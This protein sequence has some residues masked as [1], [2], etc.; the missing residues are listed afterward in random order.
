MIERAV[1]FTP[2]L[3]V[4]VGT[5]CEFSTPSLPPLPF[6]LTPQHETLPSFSTAQVCLCFAEIATAVRP[7]PK[8]STASGVS[9]FEVEPLPKNPSRPLPQ[10]TTEPLLSIA[11]VCSSPEASATGLNAEGIAA[12]GAGEEDEVRVRA[13]AR[14]GSGEDEG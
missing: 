3:D 6:A 14:V 8:G 12:I 9:W 4:K 5:N 11:Q 7:S 13:R 1:L 10:Q 2:R